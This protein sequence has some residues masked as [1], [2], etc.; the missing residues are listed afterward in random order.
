MKD[1]LDTQKMSPAEFAGAVGVDRS[2]VGRWLDGTMPHKAHRDKIRDVTD[3]RVLAADF[4]AEDDEE[5]DQ[6]NP[7][8]GAG[9]D[10][11]GKAA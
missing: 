2:T 5:E 6:S 3:A 7:A 1:W 11:Q 10:V 4:L 9:G 8:P